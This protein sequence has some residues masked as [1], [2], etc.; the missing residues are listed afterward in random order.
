[1]SLVIWYQKLKLI[2][3]L[4]LGIPLPPIFV[5]EKEDSKWELIDELQRVPT[6]LEPRK[7]RGGESNRTGSAAYNTTK[8]AIRIP[9]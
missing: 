7:R 6:I 8:R 2:E 1:V 9:R 4:L 3:S 5:F